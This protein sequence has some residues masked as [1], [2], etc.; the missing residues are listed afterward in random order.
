MEAM[1]NF[2]TFMASYMR[3]FTMLIWSQRTN[4]R[5]AERE[6][7]VHRSGVITMSSLCMCM[8]LKTPYTGVVHAWVV[9]FF[10]FFF[11]CMRI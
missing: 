1:P 8:I 7:L 3:A 6:L 2:V 4:Q 10:F 11:A 9:L 5:G